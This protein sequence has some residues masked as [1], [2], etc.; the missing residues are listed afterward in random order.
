LKENFESLRVLTNQFVISPIQKNKGFV[1]TLCTHIFEKMERKV[2]SARKLLMQNWEV[3]GEREERDITS[4]P[5][6]K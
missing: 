5:V 4:T 1:N 6:S 3:G 2:P